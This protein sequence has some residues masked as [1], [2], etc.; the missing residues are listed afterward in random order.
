[1]NLTDWLKAI[2]QN[3]QSLLDDP[4]D[5]Q[6]EASYL[7]FIVNRCLSNFPDTIFQANEMNGKHGLPN[8]MQFDYLLHS[9]KQRK[10][11]APWLKPDIPEDLDAVKQYFGYSNRRALEALTLLTPEQLERIKHLLDTGGIRKG[12]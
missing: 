9:V 7:P 5:G 1:M 8:K 12:R 4:E 2:N 3:K 6:A 11:F 10:R